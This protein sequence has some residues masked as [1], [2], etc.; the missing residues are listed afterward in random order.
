MSRDSDGQQRLWLS[1][2][3]GGKTAKKP[4]WRYWQ[5]GPK[6]WVISAPNELAKFDLRDRTL[7]HDD[8]PIHTAATQWAA[9]WYAL[10]YFYEKLIPTVQV[11]PMDPKS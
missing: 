10:A 6:H 8:R 2:G 3:Y 9:T 5:L 1:L 4:T 11:P 7:F